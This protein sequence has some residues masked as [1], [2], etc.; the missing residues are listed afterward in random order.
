[1]LSSAVKILPVTPSLLKSIP[2][3]SS[4]VLKAVGSLVSIHG[5]FPVR[6]QVADM[7]NVSSEPVECFKTNRLS[8]SPKSSTATG[9]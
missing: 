2:Y 7:L 9:V 1:M 4:A 3:S 6:V 5:R 8:P